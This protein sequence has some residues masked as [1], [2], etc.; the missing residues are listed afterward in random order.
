VSSDIGRGERL[1]Q[2]GRMKTKKNRKKGLTKTKKAIVEGTK[3][4]KKRKERI[5]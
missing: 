3:E 1:Q 2:T 4:V 5:N